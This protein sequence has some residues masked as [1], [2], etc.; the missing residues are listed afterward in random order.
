MDTQIMRI[1]SRKLPVPCHFYNPSDVFSELGLRWGSNLK[2]YHTHQQVVVILLFRV[3]PQP[4]R[5]VTTRQPLRN[6]S[7]KLITAGTAGRNKLRLCKI[8]YFQII[9]KKRFEESSFRV[10]VLKDY[11]SLM[12]Q[13]RLNPT[14]SEKAKNKNDI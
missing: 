10:K 9:Q 6:Q 2:M 7:S 3:I 8:R 14:S 1:H 11:F 12:L 4:D 13:P 5:C